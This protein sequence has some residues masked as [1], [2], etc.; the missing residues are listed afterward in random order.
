MLVQ[1][2]YEYE[3]ARKREYVELTDV[4]TGVKSKIMLPTEGWKG[5]S[6]VMVDDKTT[7]K[8][9]SLKVQNYLEMM[10][11]AIKGTVVI[12]KMIELNVIKL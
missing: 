4:T 10:H 7:P 2:K 3:K 9:I 11:S 6:T 8:E 12:K 1:V 5:E